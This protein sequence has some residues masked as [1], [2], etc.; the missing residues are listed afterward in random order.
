[1]WACKDS[2]LGR[3]L[4]LL[5]VGDLGNRLWAQHQRCEPRPGLPEVDGLGGP[6]RHPGVGGDHQHAAGAA[7]PGAQGHGIQR[8]R[9]ALVL[10][11]V[12][13]DLHHDAEHR[14]AGVEEHHEVGV[15]L[16]RDDLAQVGL[17]QAHVLVVG[18]L[19]VQDI[20]QELGRQGGPV[21]KQQDQVIY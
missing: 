7:E 9:V 15:I 2:Q 11:G 5:L 20:P 10:V 8:P 3:R 4:G 12:E 19:L 14:P 21:L 17:L 16:G 18:Q 13:L 6:A 1:M